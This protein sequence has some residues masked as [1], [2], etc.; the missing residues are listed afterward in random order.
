MQILTNFKI[1]GG[2]KL[3][4][5]VYLTPSGRMI[6]GVG[7]TPDLFVEDKVTPYEKCDFE[8]ITY[9]R[10]MRNGDTGKDVL[11]IEQ[12]LYYLGFLESLPDE[13][14]DTDT[15]DATMTFQGVTDLYEYGVMDITTQL[16]L[17]S[18]LKGMEIIN[19]RA[20]KKA[21]EIFSY[22]DWHNYKSDEYNQN[23][24]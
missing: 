24:K 7:I 18:Q 3:T 8:K 14:Y 10:V 17:D 2:I 9:D 20:L 6:D 13:T 16:K 4:E 5:A 19:D 22:E 15:Y 1:G 12:R 11:A 21:T 23:E